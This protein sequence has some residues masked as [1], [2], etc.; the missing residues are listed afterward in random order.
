[1]WLQI[2]LSDFKKHQTIEILLMVDYLSIFKNVAFFK[3]CRDF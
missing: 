3:I 1:M 2:G